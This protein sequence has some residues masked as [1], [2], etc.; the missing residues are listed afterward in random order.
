LVD[1]KRREYKVCIR[2]GV[3]SEE[4]DASRKQS[5]VWISDG[6]G[7]GRDGFLRATRCSQ[8]Q[9][10]TPLPYPV[11][12]VRSKQRLTAWP[13]QVIQ[14]TRTPEGWPD[15]Q[16]N[17]NSGAY[18]G[19]ARDSIE[20]GW[21]PDD[22]VIRGAC[23]ELTTNTDDAANLLIDPMHGMIPYQDWAKTK[24]MELRAAMFAPAKRM[25]V[26]VDVRCFPRGVV[27][28]EN[29]AGI[30]WPQKNLGPSSKLGHGR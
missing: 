12:D 4:A 13:A 23:G 28:S 16:G 7:R 27:L 22:I 3:H 15:L 29:S 24:Q 25:D 30:F 20:A 21:G 10:D 9:Y 19:G 26:D 18:P 5:S 1:N 14:P 11:K 17:W 6:G 8:Q 2:S